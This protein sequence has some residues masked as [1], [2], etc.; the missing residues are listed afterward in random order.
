MKH[1]FAIFF[2]VVTLFMQGCALRIGV[3]EPVRIQSGYPPIRGVYTP[4]C[5]P[6]LDF[7]GWGTGLMFIGGWPV[8]GWIE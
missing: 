6:C 1:L 8:L 5:A 4:F 7:Y 2:F 3:K